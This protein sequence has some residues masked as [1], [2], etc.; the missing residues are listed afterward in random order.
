MYNLKNSNK[1][2][3]KPFPPMS[4]IS[5]FPFLDYTFDK[6][7]K[8]QILQLLGEK[9]NEVIRTTNN[10][11]EIVTELKNYVDNYFTNLDVQ[12]EIN[13]KLDEMAEN[14]ELQ[15]IIN[16]Y[17]KLKTLIIFNNV[18]EMKENTN[19]IKGSYAKTLGY[20]EKNDGGSALYYIDDNTNETNNYSNILLNSNLKA[21]LLKQDYFNVEVFGAKGDGTTDD[22]K[23]I[24]NA[25]NFTNEIHFLNKTY[26]VNAVDPSILDDDI[27]KYPEYNGGINIPSNRNIKGLT[28]SKIK[29][30][31]NNSSNY[32]IFRCCQVD[33]VSISNIILEGDITQHTGENGEWGH[34]LMILNSENIN[35]EN[36][37][38]NN[39][40]ADGIYVGVLYNSNI[41][42][43][44]KNI[45]IK[46]C[47][48][49]HNGR[50]AISICS[51]DKITV[52]NN[53]LSN[54]TRTNP[55]SGIDIESEGVNP[56]L[57]NVYINNN[58]FN[59]NALGIQLYLNDTNIDFN[60]IEINNNVFNN[61]TNGIN[62]ISY[63]ITKKINGN[64]T[65]N[66]N[67]FINQG[68]T[69]FSIINYFED[70]FDTLNINNT[71]ILN[72][73]NTNKNIDDNVVGWINGSGLVITKTTSIE[74]NVGNIVINN[75][76]VIDNRTEKLINKAFCSYNQS[77]SG[78]MKNIFLLNPIKLDCLH[79]TYLNM[80]G[81]FIKDINNILNYNESYFQNEINV[82][83]IMP[84]TFSSGSGSNLRSTILNDDNDKIAN[85]TKLKFINDGNKNMQIKCGSSS[86]INVYNLGDVSQRYIRCTTSDV[87]AYIELQKINGK[88]IVINKQGEWTRSNTSF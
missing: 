44:T 51:V 11:T 62:I 38:F 15:E 77:S 71:Y 76:K 37:Q 22:T 42:K 57:K 47:V 70:L 53:I 63:T 28:N 67:S 45:T 87:G 21:N 80:Q 33:N 52:E 46:N 72:A 7:T 50:N 68:W 79:D 31:V 59:S 60:K 58:V 82:N 27:H 86:L 75:L 23:A 24:Q 73:N 9:L 36:S 16:S 40:W 18:Q 26:M 49:D 48:L 10:T 85:N 83:N 14:G 3:V 55:H 56:K 66:N 12:Q 35:I 78:S 5:E 81:T 2:Y 88:W 1:K 74:K 29:C 32:A 4:C 64:I 65:I 41:T 61:G 8:W 20:Y 39:A 13:N 25:I 43:E 17:L 30:F 34:C 84:L 54:T 6:V 69:A 19:L